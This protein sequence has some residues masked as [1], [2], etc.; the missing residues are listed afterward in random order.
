M[1][2]TPLQPGRKK[3]QA[4]ILAEPLVATALTRLD[5]HS[6]AVGEQATKQRFIVSLFL[7]GSFTNADEANDYSDIDLVVLIP[8]SVLKNADMHQH[9][10]KILEQTQTAVNAS[11]KPPAR[12]NLWPKAIEWYQN[13]RPFMKGDLS[14]FL[15][16]YEHKDERENYYSSS[17]PYDLLSLEGWSGLA[18]D[19]LLHYERATAVLLAG[20]EVFAKME[21]PDT[22]HRHEGVEL[23]LIASRDLAAGFSARAD[24]W[25]VLHQGSGNGD[26]LVRRGEHKIAKAVLRTFYAQELQ[27]AGEPLNSYGAIRDWALDRFADDDR[28]LELAEN[29]YR[30]K[31]HL[32]RTLLCSTSGLGIFALA[33]PELTSV[34]PIANLFAGTTKFKK[35]L[36]YPPKSFVQ[37]PFKPGVREFYWERTI[38]GV[39][40]LLVGRDID[41][42]ILTLFIPDVRDFL[43]RELEELKNR[44]VT[45]DAIS[46]SETVSGAIGILERC[47]WF[48]LGYNLGGGRGSAYDL[49]QM[50]ERQSVERM[51]KMTRVAQDTLYGENDLLANVLPTK[52]PEWLV[53]ETIETINILGGILAQYGTQSFAFVGNEWLQRA[54]RLYTKMLQVLATDRFREQ[55]ASLRYGYLV[56]LGRIARAC[57]NI[58]DSEQ[59]IRKLDEAISW[60]KQAIEMSP[61]KEDAHFYLGDLYITF[62]MFAKAKVCFGKAL[63]ADPASSRALGLY[64]DVHEL[65]DLKSERSDAVARCRSLIGKNPVAAFGLAKLTYPKNVSADQ[66][67]RWLEDNLADKWWEIPNVFRFLPSDFMLALVRKAP[68]T[69]GNQ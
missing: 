18:S 44:G 16:S 22:I 28:T 52:Q 2:G 69:L 14:D 68:A 5:Q 1:K 43:A 55:Y 3:T 32:E 40:K 64:V 50:M 33:N 66:L 39:A 51:E 6:L 11:A 47:I 59:T 57:T 29:A 35:Y 54:G 34:A 37:S 58:S 9:I 49:L 12:I 20:E 17:T 19:T 41:P 63:E 60:Y 7:I 38:P 26:E 13:L 8:L 10:K 45:E 61:E 30:T 53:T 48:Y 21:L 25:N 42:M 65:G 67:D 62:G 4:Q 15:W 23:A 46:D 31:V 24:G 56:R 36:I 27:E